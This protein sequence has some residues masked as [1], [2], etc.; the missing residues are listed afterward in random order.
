MF[1]C[2]YPTETKFIEQK[3]EI[4]RFTFYS[5]KG[6][7]QLLHADLRNLECLGKSVVNFRYCLRFAAPFISKVYTYPMKSRRFIPKKMSEFYEEVDEKR[8]RRKMSLQ[9]DQEFLQNEFK[10]LNKK[11]NV[12]VFVP[13]QIICEL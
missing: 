10:R 1:I 3:R 9:T 13:E 4:C 7:F 12:N 11:Y 6:S 5:F 2:V 8:K